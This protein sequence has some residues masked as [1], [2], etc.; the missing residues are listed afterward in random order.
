[1]VSGIANMETDGRLQLRPSGKWAI[2]VRGREP[3]DIAAGEVFFLEVLGE[4][5]MQQA[6]MEQREG[7]W[8]AVLKGGRVERRAELR[9]GLRAG[10]FDR[11]ERYAKLGK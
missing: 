2:G 1:V 9:E 7:Q 6:R 3:V 11:R 10:F 8:R 5:R 4:R